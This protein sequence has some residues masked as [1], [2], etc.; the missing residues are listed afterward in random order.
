MITRRQFIK[1][2]FITTNGMLLQRLPKAKAE[3]YSGRIDIA[4]FDISVPLWL[5]DKS[6][7]QAGRIKALSAQKEKKTDEIIV[8]FNGDQKL[9]LNRRASVDW[10]I[11]KNNNRAT[12][13]SM[14]LKRIIAYAMD[15]LYHEIANKGQPSLKRRFEHFQAEET[16][17]FITI[18]SLYNLITDVRKHEK[19]SSIKWHAVSLS[20]KVN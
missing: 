11:K 19:I 16:I 8:Y 9:H 14:L 7:K 1:F 18:D 17:T 3:D 20:F 15:A 6:S 5:F 13:E 12:R 4:S 10:L 2:I